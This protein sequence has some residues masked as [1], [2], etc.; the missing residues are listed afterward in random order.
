MAWQAGN[1]FHRQH[2]LWFFDV[3]SIN[4]GL[5]PPLDRAHAGHTQ[6]KDAHARNEP[7]QVAG[8][9]RL[10]RLPG[11]SGIFMIVVSKMEA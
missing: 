2:F 1:S 11:G 4:R 5:K 10:P 7:G 3:R 6:A 8:A 9:V